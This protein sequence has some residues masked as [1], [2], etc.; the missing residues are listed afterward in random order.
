VAMRSVGWVLRYGSH[1]KEHVDIC[2]LGPL[3]ALNLQ[4]QAS[5]TVLVE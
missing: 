2:T 3:A 1:I 5:W 4:L